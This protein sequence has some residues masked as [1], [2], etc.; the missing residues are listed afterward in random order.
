MTHWDDIYKNYEKGGEAW[1]T[2]AEEVHPLFMQFLERTE[3]PIKHALD[4]GCGTGKYL[5]VLHDRGFAVDGIDNS[6]TAAKMTREM[7]P[8]VTIFS[9]DMY[10]CA[11]PEQTYDLIVSVSTIH[12]STKPVIASLVAKVYAGLT[13]GGYIFITMP[14]WNRVRESKMFH[15]HTV[16]EPGT[17]APRTGPEAGLAHSFYTEEEIRDL[18]KDFRDLHFELDEYKRWVITGRR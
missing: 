9:D 13:D 11:I 1:A 5:K 17:L 14:E 4:I 15:T 8:D 6:E 3:F 2:L 10:E 18:F 16:I 12:H 7:I